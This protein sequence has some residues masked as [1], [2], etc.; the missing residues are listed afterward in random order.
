M[1]LVVSM[2]LTVYARSLTFCRLRRSKEDLP[3]TTVA[4]FESAA[5][6]LAALCEQYGW[7]VVLLSCWGYGAGGKPRP[8][9]TPMS[10]GQVMKAHRRMATLLQREGHT[11]KIAPA[12]AAKARC[13]LLLRKASL[14]A[15]PLLAK[16]NEHPSIALTHM[17]ARCVVGAVY[18]RTAAAAAPLAETEVKLNVMQRQMLNIAV[19]EALAAEEKEAVKQERH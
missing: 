11:C 14:P 16:D 10:D 1:L 2:C 4:S 19:D 17:M 9:L 18:G 15:V 8:G 13:E 6:D 7:E 3:E 5:R 12:G